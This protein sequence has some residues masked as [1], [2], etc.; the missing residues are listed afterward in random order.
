MLSHLEFGP[1]NGPR[2]SPILLTHCF[3]AT[4]VVGSSLR[5]MSNRDHRASAELAYQHDRRRIFVFHA[6]WEPSRLTLRKGF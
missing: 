2:I 3:S 5:A 6:V 4:F 1:P